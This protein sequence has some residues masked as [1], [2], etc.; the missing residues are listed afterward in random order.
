MNCP[1]CGTDNLNS[2]LYCSACGASLTKMP[3][4]SPKKRS[5]RPVTI[6]LAVVGVAI[7]LFGCLLSMAPGGAVLIFLLIYI[8][9]V[10]FTAIL[11]I[12]RV[13]SQLKAG[14]PKT[15]WLYRVVFVVLSIIA[16][17][18]LLCL[19]II[20]NLESRPDSLRAVAILTGAA[21]PLFLVVLG[22][23]MLFGKYQDHQRE[24]ELAQMEAT[25]QQRQQQMEAN[26]E[27]LAQTWGPNVSLCDPTDN[28]QTAEYVT[29]PATTPRKF[30]FVDPRFPDVSYWQNQLP[31][32]EQASK[33]EEVTWVVCVFPVI[34]DQH[35]DYDGGR[36][37]PYQTLTLNIRL[38]YLGDQ[39][40]RVAENGVRGTA[41]DTCPVRIVYEGYN[42]YYVMSDESHKSSSELQLDQTVSF[43]QVYETVNN[44]IATATEGS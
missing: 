27:T 32:D 33:P 11:W 30:L 22:A 23:F 44:L 2:R 8:D 12:R 18:I 41:Q 26:L 7:H 10:G 9:I 13:N 28:P 19:L 14:D 25:V 40:L 39:V 37:L 29:V 21:I 34:S 15:L 35:C 20:P 6:L 16:W 5:F 43:D 4:V 17:P 42:S 36:K 38:F 1:K 31:V 24:R 3:Q